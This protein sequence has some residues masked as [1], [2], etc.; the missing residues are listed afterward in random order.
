MPSHFDR[1]NAAVYELWSG[2]SFDRDTLTAHA[3]KWQVCPFEMSLDL[4]MWA[5]GIICDYNY[6]FDP[7]V[8]LKRFFGDGVSGDYIFLIDEAHNLL[9]R[10]REMYS[11]YICK[12]DVLETRKKV[13]PYSRKLSK[14]L[15]RVNR[16][17]LELKKA[18]I[19]MRYRKT[20]PFAPVSS[21]RAGGNGQASGGT[22]GGKPCGGNSGLLFSGAGFSQHLRAGG[23]KLYDL[24]GKRGGRK[25]QAASFL[26]QPGNESEG[27]SGQGKK[28]GVFFR[29]LFC[30][31]S[32]TESF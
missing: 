13:K 4:A 32:I 23:R 3:D 15:E 26:R 2:Q 22:A 11:A 19:P 9:E 24:Y 6:A 21:E 31:C 27:I 12:E 14:A 30:P 25:I 20:R 5:D 8:H 10:G 17:L 1:V 29:Q 7:N 28:H 18:A 16:Q